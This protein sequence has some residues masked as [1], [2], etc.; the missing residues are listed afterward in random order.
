M[1]SPWH[2]S[3]QVPVYIINIRYSRGEQPFDQLFPDQP[4]ALSPFAADP[5][6]PVR[7]LR[8][9]SRGRHRHGWLLEYELQ[10]DLSELRIRARHLAGWGCRAD[11][12]PVASYLHG[13][14]RRAGRP[15]PLPGVQPRPHGP[16]GGVPIFRV[17]FGYGTAHWNPPTAHRAADPLRPAAAERRRGAARRTGPASCGWGSAPSSKTPRGGW[18]TGPC[19][20]PASGLTF[21]IPTASASSSEP[22]DSALTGC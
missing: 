21:T 11:R 1:R 20:T 4:V 7:H 17:P 10:G 2:H 8:S 9:G 5:A 22:C 18:A 13:T 16:V 19:A 12:W 6:S 15:G 3:V 14:V